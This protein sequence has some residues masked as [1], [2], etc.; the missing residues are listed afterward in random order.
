MRLSPPLVERTLSQF[1]AQA[2]PD[3]H[4]AIPELNRRFGDHTFFIDDNGLHIVEPIVSDETGAQQAGQVVKLAAWNDDGK[5]T[6]LPLD[7]E[8]ID[9]VLELGSEGLH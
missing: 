4:P 9:V 2:L 5:T 8:P 6:L 3:N 1:H 7:P